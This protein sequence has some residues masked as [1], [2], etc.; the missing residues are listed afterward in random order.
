MPRDVYE[1]RQSESIV[2]KELRKEK[3][4]L[5]ECVARQDKLLLENLH[6]ES[7][8]PCQAKASS[9]KQQSNDDSQAEK[10]QDLQQQNR[11]SE[12]PITGAA[13]GNTRHGIGDSCY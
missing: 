2:C 10:A 8:R 11:P 4:T 1:T 9:S 13:T 7:S 6:E 3:K 5:E 12:K